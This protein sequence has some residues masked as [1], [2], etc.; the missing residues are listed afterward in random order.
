MSTFWYHHPIYY[1]IGH[2]HLIPLLIYELQCQNEEN[3]L[4]QT[5][6]CLLNL[7]PMCVYSRITITNPHPHF[8][9]AHV[10]E[11]FACDARDLGSLPGFGRCPG[12][13][14]G[15]PLQY[16]CLE[17]SMDREACRATVQGLQRVGHNWRDL[18]RTHAYGY[19][20]SHGLFNYWRT[21]WLLWILKKIW[22]AVIITCM[23]FLCVY[24]HFQTSW[25]NKYLGMWF[26]DSMVRLCLAL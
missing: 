2:S 15:N 9:V 26:L 22:L 20:Q 3:W 6:I 13:G 11:E 16:S 21:F 7:I 12:G 4:P 1:H 10:L 23:Q 19:L 14:N 18:A 25:V 24:I 5:T 17:N 8:L